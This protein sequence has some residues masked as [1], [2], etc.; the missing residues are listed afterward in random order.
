MGNQALSKYRLP[1]ASSTLARNSLQWLKLTTKRGVTAMTSMISATSTYMLYVAFF[2]HFAVGLD[3][4]IAE[5]AKV[6]MIP[7]LSPLFNS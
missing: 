5:M 2:S 6:N 3:E 1:A 4:F 7:C